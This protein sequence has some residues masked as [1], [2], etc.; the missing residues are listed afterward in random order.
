MD[1]VEWNRLQIEAFKVCDIDIDNYIN[2]YK[3]ASYISK[4]RTEECCHE[5]LLAMIEDIKNFKEEMI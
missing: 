3:F 1:L 2:M 4:Y 5:I